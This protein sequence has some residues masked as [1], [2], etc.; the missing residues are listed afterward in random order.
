MR[1]VLASK[2]E[3]RQQ[4][5]ETA[6]IRADVI[7]SGFDESA[8]QDPVGTSLCARLAEAKGAQVAEQLPDRDVIVLACDTVLEFEGKVHGKPRTERASVALWRRMRG[9]T[10]IIHT[11]HY[12]MVRRDGDSQAQVQVRSTTVNF[13]D[14]SDDEAIAYAA[15]GEPINAAGAFS[16]NKLGGAFVTSIIGDPY[17]VVGISL[18]LVRQMV[19]DMGVGWHT[20]WDR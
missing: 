11:G 3:A 16:I 9:H 5:L 14:I 1:V 10:A 15:T 18:P 13:A 12:V 17:N 20:L 4:V 8:I 6:G 7:P 2:S 19:I